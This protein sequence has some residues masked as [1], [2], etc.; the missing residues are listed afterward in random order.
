MNDLNNRLYLQ[1]R[2]AGISR[3]R[4]EIT[5]KLMGQKLSTSVSPYSISQEMEQT[6]QNGNWTDLPTSVIDFGT[7]TY[8]NIF[9]HNY[10]IKLSNHVHRDQ[11][12]VLIFPHYPYKTQR[13]LRTSEYMRCTSLTN[14]INERLRQSQN[15]L[16]VATGDHLYS[17][18]GVIGR[19]Y[20]VW[21]ECIQQRTLN[22]QLPHIEENV[23]LL[24]ETNGEYG[25]RSIYVL[26]SPECINCKNCKILDPFQKSLFC[27]EVNPQRESFKKI[28]TLSNSKADEIARTVVSRE[29]VTMDVEDPP[30]PSDNGE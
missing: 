25:Y 4:F 11:S 7:D 21:A 19:L 16:Y 22:H 2:K 5:E 12:I 20:L 1:A 27:L 18:Q 29:L 30:F 26:Q 14:D 9:R 28:D 6:I 3:A 15:V 8:S 13:I 24:I 23:P 17:I 10:E